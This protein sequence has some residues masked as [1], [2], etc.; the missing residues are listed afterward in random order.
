MMKIISRVNIKIFF[1]LWPVLVLVK[2]VEI[3]PWWSFIVPVLL[4]GILVSRRYKKVASFAIG[5]WAGFLVWIG[6]LI[7]FH[8][9]YD[10]VLLDKTG[11]G[12]FVVPVLSGLVGGVLTGWALYIGSCYVKDPIQ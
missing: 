8:V 2:L 10:G 11:A 9:S 7:F 3:I 12:K 4:I 5:F 1:L 6:A